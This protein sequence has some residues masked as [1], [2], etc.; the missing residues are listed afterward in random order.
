MCLGSTSNGRI[1]KNISPANII[2]NYKDGKS[3]KIFKGDKW[4]KERHGIDYVHLG[5]SIIEV[6]N[7][8]ISRDELKS[9]ILHQD[10]YTVL[11]A[12]F[13]AGDYDAYSTFIDKIKGFKIKVKPTKGNLYDFSIKVIP[14]NN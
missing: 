14:R 5:P 9:I 13:V 12:S 3:E 4:T 8:D 7:K 11:S 6:N 10:D 2:V 1:T